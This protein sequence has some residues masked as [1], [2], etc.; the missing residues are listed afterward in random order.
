MKIAGKREGNIGY[1]RA[2]LT[3]ADL[4]QA[5]LTRIP[6]GPP[7]NEQGLPHPA[8]GLHRSVQV[9]GLKCPPPRK[10]LLWV[11]P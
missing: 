9:F 5:N 6:P 3:R 4:T 8:H 10:R 2:K 7:S 11:Q 1:N